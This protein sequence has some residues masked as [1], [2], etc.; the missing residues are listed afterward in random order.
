MV[1]AGHLIRL[2][3]NLN[4]SDVFSH[5]EQVFYWKKK[6][7]GREVDFIFKFQEDF[8]PIELKY[9]NL[10]SHRDMINL[11]S[12]KKGIVVSKNKYDTFKQYSTI[13]VEIFLMLI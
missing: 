7:S 10:I 11:F 12:L 4:P 8:F 3:Y 13:P 2:V 5:H 1:L 9:Q 6:G